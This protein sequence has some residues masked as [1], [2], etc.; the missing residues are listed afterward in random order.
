MRGRREMM[1]MMNVPGRGRGWGNRG[2]RDSSPSQPT[3]QP[4]SSSSPSGVDGGGCARREG[5]RGGRCPHLLVCN[6]E[7]ERRGREHGKSRR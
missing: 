5:R 4:P 7:R 6:P 2:R 3:T 1:M